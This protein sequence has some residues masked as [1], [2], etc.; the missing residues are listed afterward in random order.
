MVYVG[1]TDKTPSFKDTCSKEM[2]YQI[3]SSIS[4]WD[5]AYRPLVEAVQETLKDPSSFEHISTSY[6]VKDDY[7]VFFMRYSATNSFWARIAGSKSVK[8]DKKTFTIV[9]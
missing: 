6:N 8:I 7:V 1:I 2:P 5:G 4:E 3:C 9:K